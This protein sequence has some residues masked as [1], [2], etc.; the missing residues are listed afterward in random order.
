MHSNCTSPYMPL[1]FRNAPDFTVSFLKVSVCEI[2]AFSV[3]D[4]AV[5]FPSEVTP[6]LYHIVNVFNE[7]LVDHAVFSPIADVTARYAILNYVSN[8]IVQSIKT[9]ILEIPD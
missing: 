4:T 5:T 6:I 3:Y 1:T 8:V 2:V 9:V 7:V